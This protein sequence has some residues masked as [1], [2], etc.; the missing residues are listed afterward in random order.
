MGGKRVRG[1]GP[2]ATGSTDFTFL[3]FDSV[4]ESKAFVLQGRMGDSSRVTGC[5]AHNSPPP[6]TKIH[7]QN[8]V[9]T[10]YNSLLNFTLSLTRGPIFSLSLSACYDVAI[11]GAG[12]SGTYA[13]WRLRHTGRKIGI[14]EQWDRIGGRIHT[15]RLPGMPELHAELG[16]MYYMPQVT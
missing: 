15:H 16:A 14:F 1:F 10:A 12:I 4:Y 9:N 2:Q 8:L 11:I 5:F 6:N 13:A 3:S 7:Q